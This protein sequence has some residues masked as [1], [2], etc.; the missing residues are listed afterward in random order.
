MRRAPSIATFLAALALAGTAAAAPK[1]KPLPGQQQVRPPSVKADTDF[2]LSAGFETVF[3]VK[4]VA[5][6]RFLTAA[7]SK[8]GSLGPGKTS[9]G[10]LIF[11][12]TDRASPALGQSYG[13]A[14]IGPAPNDP[15][16]LVPVDAMLDRSGALFVGYVSDSLAGRQNLRIAKYLPVQGQ[17]PVNTAVFDVLCRDQDRGRSVVPDDEGGVFVRGFTWDPTHDVQKVVPYTRRFSATGEQTW[18]KLDAVMPAMVAAVSN[19]RPFALLGVA[20]G[21]GGLYEVQNIPGVTP[22]NNFDA[23]KDRV[24]IVHRNADGSVAY[25]KLVAVP[26]ARSAARRGGT[27][28]AVLQVFRGAHQRPILVFESNA[29]AAHRKIVDVAADGKTRTVATSSDLDHVV[30]AADGSLV[31][32]SAPRPGSP[33]MTFTR[34]EIVADQ[35]EKTAVTATPDLPPESWATPEDGAHVSLGANGVV[36]VASNDKIEGRIAAAT[37][38]GRFI[39][40]TKSPSGT[41]ML[42]NDGKRWFGYTLAQTGWIYK[43]GAIDL[44]YAPP[45]AAIPK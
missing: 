12:V 11:R 8:P 2:D 38:A 4:A 5:G 30:Q 41:D 9:S 26:G 33:R 19:E 40:V 34:L 20:D 17:Q 21:S 10:A 1:V 25:D 31:I 15:A 23:S 39:G 37:L 6:G 45:S 7:R 3:F 27:P 43:G 16:L 29:D 44:G 36:V 42:V 13:E 18:E 24:R 35:L 28:G 14:D 22:Q 32:V